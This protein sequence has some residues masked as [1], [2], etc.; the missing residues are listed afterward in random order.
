MRS[1]AELNRSLRQ[2]DRCCDTT[3]RWSCVNLK[4]ALELFKAHPHAGH[5]HA[6][7][8]LCELVR[9]PRLKPRASVG[10][11]QL[12]G[13][14]PALDC[15]PSPVAPGVSVYVRQALLSNTEQRG[16]C[17]ARQCLHAFPDNRVD[18][19]PTAFGE[20]FAQPP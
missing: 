6:E 5:A 9:R 4:A 2:R 12:D 10:Y 19:D 7:N 16:R 14:I 13:I 18:P 8:L 15:D 3:T 11:V 20:A 17:I 1:I